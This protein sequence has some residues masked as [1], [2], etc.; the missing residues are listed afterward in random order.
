[1]ADIHFFV[2][3]E[4]NEAIEKRAEV[5]YGKGKKGEWVHDYVLKALKGKSPK[6]QGEKVLVN[7][8]KAR[9]DLKE[10][11]RE[12][13][14]TTEKLGT[15]KA[16]QDALE[17]VSKFCDQ[18][19]KTQ[20]AIVSV[21]EKRPN[22]DDT[23]KEAFLNTVQNIYTET[24]AS[25]EQISEGLAPYL[26]SE[27]ESL[28]DKIEKDA[29][30]IREFFLDPEVW[31][32]V[33]RYSQRPNRN[34]DDGPKSPRQILSQCVH[35]HLANLENR[36]YLLKLTQEQIDAYFV[37]KDREDDSSTIKYPT[38]QN[39][40]EERRRLEDF[41]NEAVVKYIAIAE[42]QDK[43]ERIRQKEEIAKLRKER[44]KREAEEEA[45][46]RNIV[47]VKHK[48]DVNEWK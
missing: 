30:R 13:K 34:Y 3:P 40:I 17:I 18:R 5:E 24:E 32:E 45:Q 25:I 10:L 33:I 38:E 39:R 16:Y 43:Q 35:E 36:I 11:R 27:K 37:R 7:V 1:L 21:L 44:E 4:E 12:F 46:E 20:E 14:D 41:A 26:D 23:E 22:W 6:A 15:L 8:E 28:R 48:T 19:Q 9:Y 29:W 47:E 2:T 31:S 42:E